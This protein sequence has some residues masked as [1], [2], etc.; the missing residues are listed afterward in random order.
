[1]L[2]NLRHYLVVNKTIE[3]EDNIAKYMLAFMVRGLFSKTQYPLAH[4]PTSNTRSDEI[5]SLTWKAIEALGLAGLHVVAVTCDGAS[6]NRRFFDIHHEA[7]P[8]QQQPTHRTP[9]PYQ[10]DSE[11]YL[12]AD[13]P[14]LIK[15]VCNAWESKTRSLWVC[16]IFKIFQNIFE[17]FFALTYLVTCITSILCWILLYLSKFLYNK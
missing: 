7:A 17:I 3:P 8:N 15:C 10:K 16:L 1:M 2:N 12:M 14:H 13:P 6:T 4:F 5:F 9:N 11:I